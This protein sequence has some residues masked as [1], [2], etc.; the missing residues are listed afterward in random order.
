MPAPRLLS[1][2]ELQALLAGLPA[3]RLTGK[4]L[5]ACW[6]FADFGAAVAFTM[7][8]AELA[9]QHDHHPEWTVRYRRVEV[10]TTTH[11]VGGL[12]QRDAQLARAVLE[13]VGDGASEAVDR[14]PS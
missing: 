3:W 10:M 2:A 14:S 11:D 12:T 7:R 5:R 8:L 13:V 1:P 9:E 6:R 4:E